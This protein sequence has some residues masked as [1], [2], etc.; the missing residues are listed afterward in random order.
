MPP[1]LTRKHRSLREQLRNSNGRSPFFSGDASGRNPFLG[2]SKTSL[3]RRKKASSNKDPFADA[4]ATELT[5]DAPDAEPLTEQDVDD[6]FEVERPDSAI[7]MVSVLCVYT[8]SQ[9]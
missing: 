6:F 4:Q 9:I 5:A 2:S 3:T 7:M 1:G 8:V